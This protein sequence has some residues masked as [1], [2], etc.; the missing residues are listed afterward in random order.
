LF[1]TDNGQKAA[2]ADIEL[3]A[4]IERSAPPMKVGRI[5]Y[6]VSVEA[7]T[8]FLRFRQESGELIVLL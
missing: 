7:E 5:G 6:I 3:Q 8:L 4:V 1:P 2:E